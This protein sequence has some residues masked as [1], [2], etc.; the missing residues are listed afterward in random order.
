MTRFGD[1]VAM[2]PPPLAMGKI[3]P[4]TGAW[5]SG[6][7]CEPGALAGATEITAVGGWRAFVAS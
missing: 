5:I 4:D 1:L 6:F 2:I 3:E 7:V